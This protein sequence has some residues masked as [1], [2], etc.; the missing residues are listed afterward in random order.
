MPIS[1]KVLVRYVDVNGDRRLDAVVNVRPV[2]LH[3]T[4]GKVKILMTAATAGGALVQG[5]AAATAQ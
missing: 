2:D 3:L 5:T 4:A 1:R